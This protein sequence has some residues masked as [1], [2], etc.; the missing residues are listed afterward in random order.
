M[1]IAEAYEIDKFILPNG[2][3]PFDDWYEG[4]EELEQVT[5]DERLIRVM[6][7]SFGEKRSLQG[8]LW[9]L[10]F[11]FGNAMR[12][13]YVHSGPRVIILL[14]GGD[15]RTQKK[16]IAKARQYWLSIRARR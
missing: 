12:L 2:R 14:I 5:L 16:D 6:S 4:L 10:K 13:Y 15:K 9:E 8:G 1:P 11:R 3:G 7:G